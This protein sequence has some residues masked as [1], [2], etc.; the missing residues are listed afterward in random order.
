MQRAMN[1]DRVRGFLKAR[2]RDLVN[3]QGE[4]VLLCG[5]GLG[6]WLLCEGYMWDL[7]ELSEF[8]RPRRMEKTIEHLCG[9][10][11]SQRF[12]RRFQDEFIAEE[13]IRLMAELGYNSLRLPMR[14]GLLMDEN[15][16]EPVFLESGFQR[17]DQLLAWAEK[18]RV[19]V[20]LD[21]HAAPGGQT[22][23]NIDDSLDDECGLFMDD[24]KYEL[25][26]SL[27]E[28]IARRYADRWIVGG[29]DL[30]NE[31][32]RPVRF[33]GDR[34]LDVYIPRLREFYRDATARIRKWDSKHLIAYESPHWATEADFFDRVYDPNMVIHFHRYGCAPDIGSLQP[35][36]DAG[37]RLN[38]PLWLGE[39]G[40]NTKTWIGAMVPLALECGISVSLWPWKK[41]GDASP[42]IVRR[43]VGWNKF[44]DC[45]AGRNEM[46]A[47]EVQAIL[48]RL[49]E[50]I[51]VSACVQHPEVTTQVFRTPGCI[52]RGT[53]FDTARGNEKAWHAEGE[54]PSGCYRKETGLEIVDPENPDRKDFVFDGP[55]NRS[56]LRLHEGEWAE[57]TMNGI[58]ICAQVEVVCLSTGESRVSV[59]QNET[60]LNRFDVSDCE[61]SQTL[62]GMSLF[63]CDSC[64]IRVSCDQGSVL[65]ERVEIRPSPEYT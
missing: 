43:P 15:E 61:Y 9:S 55:W 7:G 44:R 60:L 58:D 32:I 14:A 39:T 51:P 36:L 59:S 54:H 48:D 11:Y 21:L 45:V 3:E 20:F 23:A 42:C 56:R 40:E 49:L 37:E 53:D 46:T 8:D 33:E 65:L 35:F 17:I 47:E 18:Y 1:R 38:V 28:E 26:L 16:T 57:F 22:G 19:Y 64:R 27:W 10:R 30:L 4:E 24:G 62:S 41:M 34:D 29:Y 63:S 52:L 50:L 2:G 31:P 12:W 6:N 5:W 25:G 13:D